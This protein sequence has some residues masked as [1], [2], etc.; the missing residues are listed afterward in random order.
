MVSSPL[1]QLMASFNYVFGSKRVVHHLKTSVP[2]I[3]NSIQ[4]LGE[5]D[6]A[7]FLQVLMTSGDISSI[8]VAHTRAAF[9]TFAMILT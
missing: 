2:L 1:Y 8:C 9:L 7:L 3:C 5:P 4:R 6:F